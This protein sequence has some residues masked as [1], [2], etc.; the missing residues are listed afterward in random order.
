MGYHEYPPIVEKYKVP[1]VVTGFEPLDLVQGILT[2]VN[3][4]KRAKRSRQ[5]L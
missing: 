4:S 1:I 3:N 2:A 5:C